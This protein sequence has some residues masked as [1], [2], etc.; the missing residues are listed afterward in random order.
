VAQEEMPVQE[1]MQQTELVVQLE[2][3]EL[4]EAMVIRAR[5]A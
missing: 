1:E 5:M 3:Q 2:I 4:Q